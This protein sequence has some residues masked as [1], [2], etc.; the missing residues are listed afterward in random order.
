MKK[1]LYLL[2]IVPFLLIILKELEFDKSTKIIKNDIFEIHYNEDFEQP[3]FIKYKVLCNDESEKNSRAGLDFY[4]VP[5]I[6][7]SD[8]ADYKNNIYDK[9]H[10]VP[11]ADFCC[12]DEKLKQTF[13]YVNCALQHEKL[14]RGVWKILEDYERKLSE[15]YEVF[16]EIQVDFSNKR[17][18]TNAMIPSSFKKTLI[19]NHKR[20]SYFFKNETPTSN[21][22]E[23]YK[24]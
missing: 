12:D 1:F 7:T 9:G 14:N 13:S 23:D 17:L 5:N 16:V 4:E 15:H 8:N 21:K 6:K 20:I 11:A 2:I 24:K 10:M 22:I 19:Y 3:T 18:K